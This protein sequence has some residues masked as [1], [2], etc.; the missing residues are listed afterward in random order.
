MQ[1]IFLRNQFQILLNDTIYDT[2][3]TRSTFYPLAWIVSAIGPFTS[4]IFNHHM[5][6]LQENHTIYLPVR[7]VL[8]SILARTKY[9]R[10][11]HLSEH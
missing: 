11:P 4:M 8:T 5:Y 1:I 3:K 9:I 10:A 6:R 2:D 7:V